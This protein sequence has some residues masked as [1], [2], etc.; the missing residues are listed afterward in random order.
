MLIQRQRLSICSNWA[1]D[2]SYS[3]CKLNI[4]LVGRS[5]RSH[6]GEVPT[7]GLFWAQWTHHNILT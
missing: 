6:S 1:T 7:T 2:C 3:A 5:W 4:Y